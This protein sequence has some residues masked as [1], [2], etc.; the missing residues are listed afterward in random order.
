MFLSDLSWPASL[1]FSQLKESIIC[2][3]FQVKSE[4]TCS[5]EIAIGVNGGKFHP[6]LASGCSRTNPIEWT[7]VAVK[8]EPG[9]PGNHPCQVAEI[10][11]SVSPVIKVEVTSPIQKHP[12]ASSVGVP[13]LAAVNGK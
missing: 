3:R 2:F 6:N 1:L 12:D 9:A 4:K 7:P 11:T 13:S 5:C 10:T 8:K